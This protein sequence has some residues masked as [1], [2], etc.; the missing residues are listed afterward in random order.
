MWSNNFTARVSGTL[1]VLPVLTLRVPFAVCNISFGFVMS[2]KVPG[3]PNDRFCRKGDTCCL[4]FV[5]A[6]DLEGIVAK[7]RDGVYLEGGTGRTS[8]VK[9]KN[10]AYS[11][12]IGRDEVFKKR[13]RAQYA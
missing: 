12:M 13:A 10:P 7:H 6:R 9:L 4:Q 3:L 1:Q 8:W 5:C 2:T 11:Q